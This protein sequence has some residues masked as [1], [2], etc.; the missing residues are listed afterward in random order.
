MLII[1]V[2]KC[3]VAKNTH[4]LRNLKKDDRAA[5]CAGDAPNGPN[6]A[7][8]LGN[9][10][11]RHLAAHQIG[12]RL[13]CLGGEEFTDETDPAARSLIHPARDEGGIVPD[14]AIVA[15]LAEQ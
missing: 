11:E 10:F 5:P 2:P 1:N 8:D 7:R 13:A 12:R 4:D 15:A 14:A 9:M 6:K 3:G